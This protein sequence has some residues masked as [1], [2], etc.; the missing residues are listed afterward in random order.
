MRSDIGSAVPIPGFYVWEVPGKPVSIQL[1]L[2]VVEG[3]QREVMRGFGAVPRRGAEVGG[4]LIGT[5]DTAGRVFVVDYELVPISYKHGPF[6]QFSD[7]DIRTFEVLLGRLRS[8]MD[9]HPVGY[10]RSHTRDGIGLSEEDLALLSIYFPEPETVALLIRPF[11]AK[12][13]MAGF[14]FKEAGAYQSGA[15]LR[16]FPFRRKELA[17]RETAPPQELPPPQPLPPRSWTG[18]PAAREALGA[19]SQASVAFEAPSPGPARTKIRR[20]SEWALFSIILVLV[21]MW[22]GY[23]AAIALQPLPRRE[24][25]YPYPLSLAATESSCDLQLQWNRLSP[26]IQT[27]QRGI[28]T[29]DDGA[30]HK[31][32]YL[33]AAELQGRG[34]NY[35][36]LTKHVR[37]RLNV[38]LNQRSAVSESVEWNLQETTNR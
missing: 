33:T 27:A 2:D 3:L 34:F 5:A 7:D 38:F 11:A 10:F 31:S 1:S 14:Y 23:L 36:P 22:L 29:I 13:C 28:L 4:I 8:R 32:S 6:Y 16:E 21:S 19:E 15:P 26:A 18:N 35:H 24:S 9:R 30:I 17:P 25:E 37:F 12:P 20:S